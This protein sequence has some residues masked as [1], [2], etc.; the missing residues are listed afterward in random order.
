M[1]R[2]E[3]HFGI[4]ERGS[5]GMEWFA[6]DR[7]EQLTVFLPPIFILLI[8][9][10]IKLPI[11]IEPQSSSSLLNPAFLLTFSLIVTL[12]QLLRWPAKPARPWV[13]IKSEF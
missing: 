4:S 7:F 8:I 9:A 13:K 12:A 10:L 1:D 5:K 11:E 6:A 2:Q 3:I